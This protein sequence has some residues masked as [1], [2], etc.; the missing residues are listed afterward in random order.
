M[1]ND[2]EA[3]PNEILDITQTITP[4]TP[5]WPG[6]GS[7]AI[8]RT[9]TI[10]PECPVLVSRI[11][12]S[13]HTGTHADAPCHYDVEG[14]Q[15][16]SVALRPY[17]GRCVV[18]NARGDGDVVQ[19]EEIRDAV[20]RLTTPPERV[21]IRTFTQFPHHEWPG[22]FRGLAP[23]MIAYLGERGCCLIGTDAPSIDPETSKTL[24]AHHT[25]KR[26]RMAI[27]EGL[28]LDHVDPGEYELVAL[29]LRLAAADASP[30]RAVLRRI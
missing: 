15:M 16:E 21:L 20:D 25:V 14:K 28:V 10:G 27:L 1:A 8:D 17:L 29:P 18:V 2:I 19:L 3:P 6:D 22:H 30:V 11:A 23:A 26:H 7:Y 5:V 9:W 24:D 13:T 12:M 4:D